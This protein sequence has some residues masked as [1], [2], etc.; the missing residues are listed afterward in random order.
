MARRA[1]KGERVEKKWRLQMAIIDDLLK[2]NVVAGLAVGL[3]VAVLGPVIFPV[4]L[5]AARPIAKTLVKT[6]I[7]FY[8]RGRE[9]AAEFGEFIED[10]AAEAQAE[11]ANERQAATVSAAAAAPQ[12]VRPE[13]VKPASEEPENIFPGSVQ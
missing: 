7:E 9:A 5:R 4:I 2:G 3:G 8:E 11:L 6:G 12:A 10:T 1:Q 13:P